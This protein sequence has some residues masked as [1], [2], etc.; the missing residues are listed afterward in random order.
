MKRIFKYLTLTGFSAVMCLFMA[1]TATAQHRGGSGGGGGGGH[2]GG[3]GGGFSGG[4]HV[5]SGFSSAGRS[6]VGIAPRSSFAPRSGSFAPRT[7]SVSSRNGVVASRGSFGTRTGAIRNGAVLGVGTHRGY[8]PGSVGGG[9]YGHG[10]YYGHTHGWGNNGGYF[11]YGG[12]Y[13]SLYYPWLGL[14]FGFLPYGYYSFYWGGYPYFYSDGFFY[15]YN[16]NQYTV[17]EPPVGA[18]IN[19]LPNGAQSIVIDGQQYYEKNGVYYQAVTKD[20]GTVVYQVMGKDGHLNT[21]ASGVNSVMP[22]VGDI[23]SKLPPDCRKVKLS[24]TTYYVSEDG[25]YYQE[26]RDDNGK[27]AYKIVSIDGAGTA[28]NQDN[29]NSDQSSENQQ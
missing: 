9:V 22:R 23:V 29:N 13:G 26:I 8:V 2:S 20:D 16:D 5:S 19:A 3:G 1:A 15:T 28:D 10:G 18:A 6:S 27:K 25:I 7:G 14:G 21:S 11:Y 4:G 24:G 12:Y 17:V